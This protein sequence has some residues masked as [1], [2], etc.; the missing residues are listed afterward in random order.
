MKK[1]FTLIELV[2]S[3][4][5]VVI[6]LGGIFLLVRQIIV[7][8]SF[9]PN[10]LIA[11]YLAQEGIEIVRNIRDTNW[12][13]GEN[14]KAGLEGYGSGQEGCDVND[15]AALSY[16]S[17]NLDNYPNTPLHI[18]GDFYKQTTLGDSTSFKRRI[19][20]NTKTD[21]EGNEYLEVISYVCWKERG[22][23]HQVKLIENLYDWY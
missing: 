17:E 3:I 5:V 12:R 23:T 13:E 20:V 4:F 10:Q 9:L 18:Y 6:A 8:T 22:R 11:T 1:S 19:V 15:G 2:T 21:S 14:W 7:A 16:D